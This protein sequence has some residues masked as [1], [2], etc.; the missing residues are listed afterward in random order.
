M[1]VLLLLCV[2]I[3]EGRGA[4]LDWAG[5]VVDDGVIVSVVGE[6]KSELWLWMVLRWGWC[7]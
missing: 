7:W 3:P 6:V 5:V 4:L 1:R 2:A